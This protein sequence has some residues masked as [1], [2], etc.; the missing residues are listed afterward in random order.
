L[1]SNLPLL[2]GIGLRDPCLTFIPAGKVDEKKEEDVPMPDVA[3][4]PTY[5]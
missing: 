2:V 4:D 3:E 5:H 1:Q